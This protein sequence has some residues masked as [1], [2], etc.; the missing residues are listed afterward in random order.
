MANCQRLNDI[1]RATDQ[2]IPTETWHDVGLESRRNS[3]QTQRTIKTLR[4]ISDI[5]VY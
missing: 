2:Q 1:K 3:N 4:N 5:S